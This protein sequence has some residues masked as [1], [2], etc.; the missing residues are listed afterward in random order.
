MGYGAQGGTLPCCVE[1]STRASAVQVGTQ[2]R[3][4]WD[5]L[6]GTCEGLLCEAN[7]RTGEL[8]EL[9]GARGTR[10]QVGR[11]DSHTWPYLMLLPQVRLFRTAVS[12]PF[13]MRKFAYQRQRVSPSHSAVRGCVHR[14]AAKAVLQASVPP[15]RP[16]MATSAAVLAIV[17]AYRPSFRCA[18]T[19]HAHRSATPRSDTHIAPSVV[20]VALTLQERVRQA[21]LCS[22]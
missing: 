15:H 16:P 20:L 8:G 2:W 19:R 5:R 21:S 1:G 17:R 11:T 13:C 4:S 14:S 3:G 22:S 10:G 18:S 9:A 6:G 7:A 12:L